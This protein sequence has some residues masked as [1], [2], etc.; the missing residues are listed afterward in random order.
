MRMDE[1]GV[2]VADPFAPI[3][4]DESGVVVAVPFVSIRIDESGVTVKVE[5]TVEAMLVTGVDVTVF[6]GVVKSGDPVDAWRVAHEVSR[7][8][9]MVIPMI[10]FMEWWTRNM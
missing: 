3:R 7:T 8:M 5:V 2:V 4:M 6:E 10:S 9:N 1:S